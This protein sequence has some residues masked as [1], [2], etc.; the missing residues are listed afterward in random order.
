MHRCLFVTF[1]LLAALFV[2]PQAAFAGCVVGVSP[3]QSLN[4]RTGPS[5]QTDAAGSIPSD[6]CGVQ[7]SRRC[8]N[9][10][11]EVTYKGLTGWASMKFIDRD[12]VAP[13]APVQAQAPQTQLMANDWEFLGARKIDF[14]VDRDVIPVSRREGRFSALQLV[15]KDADVG[16][17]DIRVTYGNGKVDDI[18]VRTVI[19]A[20]RH[21]KIF[22]LKGGSRV[23][24]KVAITYAARPGSVSVAEVQ[25][26]GLAANRTVV[27]PPPVRP[28]APRMAWTLL[29]VRSVTFRPDRD[30]ISVG[31]DAGRFRALQ[32]VVSD[33]DVV[34]EDLKVVYGNGRF[35]D[36]QIRRRIPAGKRSRIIDLKGQARVIREIRLIYRTRPPLSEAGSVAVYGLRAAN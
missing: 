13:P 17:R 31:A 30:I 19:G 32:L 28:V 26:Y 14:K 11:C 35:D 36:I 5:T 18:Q 27:S 33:N 9:N 10:W 2:S 7:V 29:D 8:Q 23:I 12:R 1:S 16:V 34:F 4:I 20:G 21:S 15:A 3:G 22:D 6:A 24:R 25:L